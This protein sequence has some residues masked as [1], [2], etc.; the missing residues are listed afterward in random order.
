MKN[1]AERYLTPFFSELL[2]YLEQGKTGFHTP[3][4]RGGISWGDGWQP[5]DLLRVDLTELSGLDWERAK[6]D[7][8]RLAAEFY[9]ADQSFFLVQGA[10][11]GLHASMLG[12]F[13]PGDRVF[14][15]R[16]C[17]SSVYNGLILADLYP[18]YI[19]IDYVP[20][21]GLPEGV[22]LAALQQAVKD[23]PEAKGLILTNPTYQ[24]I[25]TRVNAIRQ[26]IGDRILIIDEA[27]GGH[28]EWWGKPDYSAFIAADLWIQGT[29]KFLGSLTQTGFLHIKGPRVDLGRIA[30]SLQWISTTSPSFVFMASLDLNRAYLAG[31]GRTLFNRS[32]EQMTELKRSLTSLPG[33]R[34]LQD[35]DT[36]HGER[37]VDPWRLS[38]SWLDAGLT[39]YEVDRMLR[40]E[41]NI[42]AEYADF[43]QVTLLCPPWQPVADLRQLAEAFQRMACRI[44]G[45]KRRFPL[46]FRM[47]VGPVEIAPR[48]IAFAQTRTVTPEMAVGCIAA[49][50]IAP[51][52]PGIPLVGPGERITAEMISVLRDIQTA[53]G[54]VRGMNGRG[55]I[56]IS[57]IEGNDD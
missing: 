37:I 11:Q 8:E 56:K 28:F 34:V 12:C 9:H 29:H 25:A 44:T 54:T 17:H 42:Q 30:R 22:N 21:W 43:N 49:E 35:G 7:A 45:E 40:E 26:V 5:E 4:H 31:E 57:C 36:A 14:V 55:E 33:I 39:G 2:R 16:N 27:H 51:Y 41:Y 3:G 23:H 46:E 20:G 47:P 52:P 18:I 6:T 38:C 10:T 24:G 1:Q 48:K 32:L 19:D 13:N 15:A 53:G 50:V